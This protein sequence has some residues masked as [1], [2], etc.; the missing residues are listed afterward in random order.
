[1]NAFADVPR[2]SGRRPSA[3]RR[4]HIHF[5][6]IAFADGNETKHL[7]YGE[8]TLRAEPLPE[9]LARFHRPGTNISES[10]DEAWSQAVEGSCSAR[11]QARR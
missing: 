1:V 2:A 5:S 10:P 7:F 9:A 6:D 4:F 3:R 8:V 11:P